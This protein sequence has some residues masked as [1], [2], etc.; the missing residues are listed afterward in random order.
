MKKILTILLTI[1]ILLCLN[2]SIATSQN[3]VGIS[4][5]KDIKRLTNLQKKFNETSDPLER[6]FLTEAML[7]YLGE[8]R[9]KIEKTNAIYYKTAI[10]ILTG[11]IKL[12][13]RSPHEYPKLPPGTIGP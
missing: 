3:E 1:F 7:D 10:L 2:S 6:Y 11:E 4:F 9:E 8:M 13:D 12:P 5:T